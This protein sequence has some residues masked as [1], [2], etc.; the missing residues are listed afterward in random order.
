MVSLS[1]ALRVWWKCAQRYSNFANILVEVIVANQDV[2][3]VADNINDVEE[4]G[5][6]PPQLLH[7]LSQIL[8]K[9]RVLTPRTLQLF[10][11]SEFDA[12][13]IYDC[14]SE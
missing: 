6:L 10:L 8:S 13:N 2:Q 14:G 5:D 7:R 11:R 12:I 9:R 1:K 4:F 3:K